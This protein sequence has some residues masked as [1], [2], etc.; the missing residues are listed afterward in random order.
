MQSQHHG[1]V[2]VHKSGLVLDREMSFLGASPDRLVN[3]Q[4]C[5]PVQGLL[6]VKCPSVHKNKTPE[7]ACGDSDK[8]RAL[9]PSGK[10]VC[11]QYNNHDCASTGSVVATSMPATPVVVTILDRTTCPARRRQQAQA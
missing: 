5:Q 6:E 2:Q 11:G 10:E 7:E 9:G 1:H 4:H 8:R 3:C